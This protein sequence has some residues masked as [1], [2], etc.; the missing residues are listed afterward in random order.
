MLTVRWWG[1]GC[2]QSCDN[3]CLQS[4]TVKFQV[5]H[6]PYENGNWRYLSQ[7]LRI[8]EATADWRYQGKL[9]GEK[10]SVE[11]GLESRICWVGA[12]EGVLEDS[13]AA[14]AQRQEWGRQAGQQRNFVPG[15]DRFGGVMGNILGL[16][17]LG[18]VVLLVELP[19]EIISVLWT[20]WLE[21]VS[22]E[23]SALPLLYKKDNE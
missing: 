8:L 1:W 3:E 17:R 2:L 15:T 4:T 19:T 6:N 14:G 5:E 22:T 9:N 18:S 13:V 20:C 11:I 10:L 23:Q 21:H 7:Q 16:N 12:S